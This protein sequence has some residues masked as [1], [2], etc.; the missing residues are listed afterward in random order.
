[1]ASSVWGHSVA[2]DAINIRDNVMLLRMGLNK[3]P[4]EDDLRKLLE[5]KLQVVDDM[6]RQIRE[7]PIT[8][9]LSYSEGL[10]DVNVNALIRKRITQLWRNAR[11]KAIPHRLQLS[12]VEPIVHC[13]PEWIKRMLEFLIDNAID[14][15]K[16][17]PNP[18][19]TVGTRMLDEAVEITVADTGPGIPR[20]LASKLFKQRI[21]KLP[22]SKGLGTGLLIAQAIA[23]TYK[24][25]VGVSETSPRGTT[26]HVRLP[27]VNQKLDA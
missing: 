19:I 14:A 15:M 25:E 9:L 7:K 18:L 1:M 6:A 27:V 26:V 13:S 24:G 8:A 5:D 10:S 23:R 12:E 3:Y 11:Y 4:L 22:N 2:G 16:G 21:E 20:E 17:H